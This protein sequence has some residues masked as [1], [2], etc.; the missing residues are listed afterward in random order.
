MVQWLLAQGILF[1]FHNKGLIQQRESCFTIREGCSKIWRVV[2]TLGRCS[3]D[4]EVCSNHGHVILAMGNVAT[5]GEVVPTL[6]IFPNYRKACLTKRDLDFPDYRDFYPEDS[7]HV[8]SKKTGSD[9][10]QI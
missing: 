2:P 6:E 5:T 8:V 10:V 9:L 1:V 4:K 7:V 3:N